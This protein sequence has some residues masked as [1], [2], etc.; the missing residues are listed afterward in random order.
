VRE[1]SITGLGLPGVDGNVA[2][3]IAATAMPAAAQAAISGGMPSR[4]RPNVKGAAAVIAA[5]AA[6]QATAVRA[7]TPPLPRSS[8]SR[9]AF[10]NTP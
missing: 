10:E 2:N 4:E 6:A 7:I 8:K 5:T 3:P 1:C 9:F